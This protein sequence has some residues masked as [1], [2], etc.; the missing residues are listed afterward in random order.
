MSPPNDAG[1]LV[2]VKFRRI[3]RAGMAA[4]RHRMLKVGREG[5]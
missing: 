5:L 2:S 1:N 4:S 3:V